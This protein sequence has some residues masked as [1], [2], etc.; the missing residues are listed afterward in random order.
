MKT[1]VL[2]TVECS[3]DTDDYEYAARSLTEDGPWLD[4]TSAGIHGFY[5]A[6][7]LRVVGVK[8]VSA[9]RGSEGGGRP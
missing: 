1:R 6:K 7:S 2:I 3:L 5:R 8:R 9:R 4:V